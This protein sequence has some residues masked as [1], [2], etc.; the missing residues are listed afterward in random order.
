MAKTKFIKYNEIFDSSLRNHVERY[1]K[2]SWK[3]GWYISEIVYMP[4]KEAWLVKWERS[5]T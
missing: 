3:R 2:D 1:Y 5:M 4:K